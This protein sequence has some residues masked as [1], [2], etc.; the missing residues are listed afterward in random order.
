MR[1]AMNKVYHVPCFVCSMCRKQ[2][3]TGEQIYLVQVRG[4]QVSPIAV[5]NKLVHYF[6]PIQEYCKHIQEYC[7]HSD[8]GSHSL[9]PSLPPPFLLSGRGLSLQGLLPADTEHC[10]G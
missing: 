6:V 3:T 1:H 4:G 8:Y 7:K 9:R 10:Y 5:S 2:L